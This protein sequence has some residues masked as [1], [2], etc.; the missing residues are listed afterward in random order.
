METKYSKP[1]LAWFVKNKPRKE[2]ERDK[3]FLKDVA[4]YYSSLDELIKVVEQ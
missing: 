3:R 2:L 4:R 1:N